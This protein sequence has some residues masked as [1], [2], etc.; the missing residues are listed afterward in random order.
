MTPEQV[1]YGLSKQ[2][3]RQREAV[4]QAAFRKNQNRF[5][6]KIPV[7]QRVPKAAWINSPSTQEVEV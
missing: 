6:N 3:Y 5:K 4:L 2:I 7:P 1:H